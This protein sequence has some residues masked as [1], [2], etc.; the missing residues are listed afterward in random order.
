MPRTPLARV[1]FVDTGTG[2]EFAR[3]ELAAEQLPS[4]EAVPVPGADAIDGDGA[5]TIDGDGAR[6]VIHEDD[7]RQ[8]E[9]VS[10]RLAGEAE[11]EAEAEA[12]LRAIRRIH[13]QHSRVVG[14]GASQVRVFGEVRIR[15]APPAPLPA[16]LPQR[17]LFELLPPVDRSYP[18]VGY[19]DGQGRVVD[20]FAFAVAV[21]PL[22]RYGQAAGGLATVLG[23]AVSADAPR[24]VAE[25]GGRPDE[26]ARRPGRA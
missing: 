3:A 24:A 4:T 13:R 15:R 9:P 10:R 21:G 2:Q 16:G 14:E 17:R 23:L 8:T 25:A 12:E 11:V 26:A 6:F 20:S 1:V 18:G 5:R 19:R 22:A 7:R